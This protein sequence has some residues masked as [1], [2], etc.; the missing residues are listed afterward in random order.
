MFACHGATTTKFTIIFKPEPWEFRVF[1]I[2]P[3]TFIIKK[4]FHNVS[5][6]LTQAHIDSLYHECVT[7]KPNYIKFYDLKLINNS[8]LYENFP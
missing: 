6:M 1:I 4:C 8:T 3:D 5:F 7:N 2:N